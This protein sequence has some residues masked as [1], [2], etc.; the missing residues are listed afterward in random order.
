[1]LKKVREHFGDTRE[2]F[3]LTVAGGQLHVL[4]NPKDVENAYKNT[5]TLTFDGFVQAIMRT[6]GSSEYCINAM[7]SYIPH[8]PHEKDFPNPL[9]KPVAKLSKDLHV[10]QLFPGDHLDDLGNKFANFFDESLVLKDISKKDYAT[11]K[12]PESIVVPL[13]LWSSEVFVMGGQRAYFGRLLEDID[14]SMARRFIEFD[15]LDWQ[16]LF[17]YPRFASRRMH[18]LA[19][20]LIKNL[21]T[22][23]GTPTEKRMGDAWFTKA[24]EHEARQAGIGTHEIATMML[25]VYWG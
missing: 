9:K 2:P 6:F 16:V 25:T 14:P 10:K 12:T 4:T 7:Y 19:D 3:T 17:Q 21:E 8:S 1:M 23:H 18:A 15:E 5:S 13:L 11:Q 22:Y 20:S 24:F